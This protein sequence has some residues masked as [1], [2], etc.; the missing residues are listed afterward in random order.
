M[1]S[2]KK[3]K[4]GN[5]IAIVKG[6]NKDESILYL[7]EEKKQVYKDNLIDPTEYLTD[8]MFYDKK[9]RR[10]MKSLDVAKIIRAVKLNQDEI[11]DEHLIETF[12]N[13]KKVLN[14]KVDREIQ[15]HN[16][17][18]QF[19][20][21]VKV[22]N[23][24]RQVILV[25]GASGSGK[26][27][28]CA[29]YAK[30]YMDMFPR[31]PVYLF[32]KKEQDEVF[33]RYTKINRILLDESFLEGDELSYKDFKDSLVIFDDIDTIQ[34]EVGKEIMRLRSDILQ[35]GRDS[36]V[37]VCVTTHIV[38]NGGKTKELINEATH[39]VFFR[40]TNKLNTGRLLMNY[41]GIPQN[42][43]KKIFNL[44]SRWTL[45]SKNYPAYI[46]YSSGCY[47]IN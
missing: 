41:V 23:S 40:G 27:Y 38:C 9:L 24:S 6:G 7:Y 46:M 17:S 43:L 11:Y 12:N 8:D 14:E 13:I 30:T 20:P 25:S 32:S 22:T 33:D 44:P 28:W 5:P 34:G 16:G 37:N 19:L 47:L 36:N 4:N 35:L 45:V 31:N 29:D 2:F 26:S 39:Y 42:D 3:H 10:Q 21:S 18:F 1:I 15:L